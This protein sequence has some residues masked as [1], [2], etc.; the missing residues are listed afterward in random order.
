MDSLK[1]YATKAS[2]RFIYGILLTL[3]LAC[4]HGDTIEVVC[5]VQSS[6]RYEAGDA[7]SIKDISIP[8]QAI[9]LPK[10]GE[11]L[12]GKLFETAETLVM[13]SISEVNGSTKTLHID[14]AK[15]IFQLIELSSSELDREPY[16]SKGT[17]I[18]RNR[19]DDSGT[20]LP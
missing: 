2:R 3:S 5:T 17:W 11:H 19:D 15:G 14:R 6:N 9:A 4:S 8:R 10:G 12:F 1:T 20:A 7:F 13:L 16:H 18:A